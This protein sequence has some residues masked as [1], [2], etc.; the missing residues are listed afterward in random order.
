MTDS[1]SGLALIDTTNNNQQHCHNQ[2]VCAN[3]KFS[4]HYS[5]TAR[6]FD[7]T[8]ETTITTTTGGLVNVN[9][10][11]FA[12]RNATIVHNSSGS[13][14]LSEHNHQRPAN[15][16]ISSSV[17]LAG[18][19]PSPPPPPPPSSPPTP[20]P[21]NEH[22]NTYS[23]LLRYR[24]QE[25]YTKLSLNPS[26]DTESEV[27]S[28][29]DSVNNNNVSTVRYKGCE[30][31]NDLS[32]SNL[33]SNP[34]IDCQQQ[35]QQQPRINSLVNS[36]SFYPSSRQ[37]QHHHPHYRNHL[38]KAYQSSTTT[39]NNVT[40]LLRSNSSLSLS[41]Y[42]NKRNPAVFQHP[43][44]HQ[45][46][47]PQSTSNL[48][49][50]TTAAATLERVPK[51]SKQI[52]KQNGHHKSTMNNL[53]VTSSTSGAGNAGGGDQLT[54]PYTGPLGTAV[55]DNSYRRNTLTRS[56]SSGVDANST[57]LHTIPIVVTSAQP[58]ATVTSS[59]ALYHSPQHA[60]HYQQQQQYQLNGAN[61][62]SSSSLVAAQTEYP[63][64]QYHHS[65][66]GTTPAYITSGIYNGPKLTVK[67]P[68]PTVTTTTASVNHHQ[69]RMP[70]RFPT[71]TSLTGKANPSI[72]K[73]VSGATV[74][75]TV[76]GTLSVYSV[77][78]SSQPPTTT[79]S[80]ATTVSRTLFPPTNMFESK[81]NKLFG[82]VSSIDIQVSFLFNCF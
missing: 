1:S 47:Y 75:S 19:N 74:M 42:S 56:S 15:P 22:N 18:R 32:Q 54:R 77:A 44:Y 2:Q 73:F 16:T 72:V 35:Q 62:R 36:I 78:A 41:V 38:H 29:A 40:G 70:A 27:E 79:I 65:T 82:S 64:A 68:L 58:T 48:F 34:V 61:S 71:T 52:L 43:R 12:S 69:H 45:Y 20:P 17:T 13:N 81:K 33:Y 9:K 59:S 11:G 50:T 55:V 23:E 39:N 37:Y 25:F 76:P 30:S 26:T 63:N 53:G 6:N 3:S 51:E 60:I 10:R 4:N 67:N 8:V 66:Y 46:L 7:G 49:T 21:R 80:T 14:H 28:K 31:L 57:F 5:N 24:S